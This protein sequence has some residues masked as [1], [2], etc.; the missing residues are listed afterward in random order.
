MEGTYRRWCGAIL[1]LICDGPGV[2]F[3]YSLMPWSVASER[4]SGEPLWFLYCEL[5][6][7]GAWFQFYDAFLRFSSIAC[8]Y[9]SKIYL[10]SLQVY[11]YFDDKIFSYGHGRL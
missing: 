9:K 3:L 1:V 11:S 4:I 2:I 7:K 5:L 6:F 8:A 10:N